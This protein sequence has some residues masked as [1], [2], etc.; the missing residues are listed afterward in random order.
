[1][2]ET[3]IYCAPRT[4]IIT[5]GTSKLYFVVIETETIAEQKQ[6][7]RIDIDHLDDLPA[8]NAVW[9]RTAGHILQI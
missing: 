5:F 8:A 1:M 3:A 2:I 6:N 9:N 4:V 7:I